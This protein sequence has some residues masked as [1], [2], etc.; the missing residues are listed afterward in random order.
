MVTFSPT[1]P[2][3]GASSPVTNTLPCTFDFCEGVEFDPQPMPIRL[4]ASSKAIQKNFFMA[5]LRGESFFVKRVQGGAAI[6]FTAMETQ[7]SGESRVTEEMLR[8]ECGVN[9]SYLAECDG[10]ARLSRKKKNRSACPSGR[11]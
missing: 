11:E 8:G 3:A 9:L 5:E 4:R 10:F 7:P 1:T 2:E 6:C